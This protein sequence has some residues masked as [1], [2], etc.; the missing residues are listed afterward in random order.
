MYA[1]EGF[2]ATRNATL[3]AAL[4]LTLV[5]LAIWTPAEA[6]PDRPGE[7]VQ[8]Q[9]DAHLKAYPGGVQTGPAEITYKNGRFVMTFVR[10][11]VGTAGVADCP[12]GWFC[13][14]DFTNYGYPRGKLSD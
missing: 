12:A 10:P 3:I 5:S 14:Y 7:D 4:A 11:D 1:K 8:A 6:Q 9:I 2:M 13:F